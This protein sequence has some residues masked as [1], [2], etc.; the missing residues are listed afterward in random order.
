MLGNIFYLHVNELPDLLAVNQE[1]NKGRFVKIIE[2]IPVAGGSKNEQYMQYKAQ[3][4]FDE[5][6]V[7]TI[8]NYLSPFNFTPFENLNN[9][10]NNLSHIIVPEKISEMNF[11]LQEVQDVIS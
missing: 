10:I 4:I 3:C 5:S 8:N 7:Y 11:I 9:I 6:K 1:L 2:E